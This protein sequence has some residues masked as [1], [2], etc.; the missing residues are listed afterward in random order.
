MKNGKV[1]CLKDPITFEIKY[2]GFTRSTLSTRFSQHKHEALKK[3][4]LS[5]CYNWFRK[6]C[7]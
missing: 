2:I 5:H 7:K 3:N 6:M 1:Y 4:T